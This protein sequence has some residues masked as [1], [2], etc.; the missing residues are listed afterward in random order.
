MFSPKQHASQEGFLALTLK[1]KNF[2]PSKMSQLV[3]FSFSG[4]GRLGFYRRKSLQLVLVSNLVFSKLMISQPQN[5]L[6]IFRT[7]SDVFHTG[8]SNIKFFLQIAAWSHQPEDA[9][10]YIVCLNPVLTYGNLMD[11]HFS[12][13]KGHSPK[14]SFLSFYIQKENSCPDI[15]ELVWYYYPVL[16]PGS[17]G[18]FTARQWCFINRTPSATLW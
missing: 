11:F 18:V 12:N 9:Y 16:M 3:R 14:V 4:K 2:L 5:C 10:P 7:R 8:V 6:D 15:W 13:L 17:S 1:L